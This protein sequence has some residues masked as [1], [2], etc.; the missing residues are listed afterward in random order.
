MKGTI[1]FLNIYLTYINSG[2]RS[3][4]SSLTPLKERL[5]TVYYGLAFPSFSPFYETFNDKIF[6]LFDAGLTSYWI[7]SRLNPRSVIKKVEDIGPEV[8]TMEHLDIAFKIIMI[9]VA[10]CILMFLFEILFF[11]LH[12]IFLMYTIRPR[13]IH[14][15][16]C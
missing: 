6:R 13:I 14:V 8:L 3:G 9:A 12:K 7:Q 5:S 15:E 1:L 4:F 2:F 10:I 11:Q 16:P